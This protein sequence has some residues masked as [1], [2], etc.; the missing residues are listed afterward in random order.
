VQQVR[1]VGARV[2]VGAGCAWGAVLSCLALRPVVC[3]LVAVAAAA[4]GC[5]ALALIRGRALGGQLALCAFC[6]AV[7]LVPLAARQQR[8]ESSP[9][10]T[11]ARRHTTVTLDLVTTGDPQT[12][13]AHGV[14]G[15]PRVQVSARA[16][17]SVAGSRR[18]P[19]SGSVLIIAPAAQWRDLL[20]GQPIRATVQLAPSL[21][22]GPAGVTAFARDGPTRTGAPPWWQRAAGRVRSALRTAAAGLPEQPRGLLP[23]LVDGDTS[24]LDPILAEHFR[25]AGLTHL[26][27]V[28]G[29]NCSVLIGA[30]LL[31]M[32]RSRARPWLR[33]AVAFVVLVGFVLV[34]RPSPSVL[35]AAV[36]ATVALGALAAGRPRRGLPALAA[37]VV[38]L[39]AW[40]PLLARDVGFALSVFA[41]AAVLTIAP[42]LC[43]ALER[44]GLPRSIAGL[45]A[46]AAAAH[47]VTAPVIAAISGRVSLVTIP[48]NVVAEPVVAITTVLGFVVA[49]VAPVWAPA[50]AA[51]AQL[52]GL[53][54]R[55][56]V[57]DADF[58]GGLHGATLPWPAGLAGGLALAAVGA[59]IVALLVHSTTARRLVAA[60]VLVGVLVQIPVRS[61]VLHWPPNGWLFVACDVG[62]GDGLVLDAG[63]GSAVVVDSGPDP[64]PMDRCLSD[65]GVTAV[66]L[67]VFTHLHLDH[68]GGVAGVL[69][70]RQV[71][72]VVTGPLLEPVSG[73]HLV[74]AALRPRHL[75][76]GGLADGTSVRV[77]AV[78]LSV[79]GPAAAFHDTRSDPNN[80]SLVLRADVDGVRILLTGDAEIEAQQALL[81]ERVDL[82]AD[83]LKVPHHGSAYSL[84]AFLAAV[85]AQVGVISVGLHNDYG[86]PSPLLLHALERIGLPVRRTDH[87]GDVAFAGRPGAI[88][89]TTRGT[90]PS[91]VGLGPAAPPGTPS[92]LLRTEWAA[93][94]AHS[95]PIGPLAGDDRMGPCPPAPSRSTSCPTSSRRSSCWSATRSCSSPGR[96]ARSPPPRD[97]PTRTLS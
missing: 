53:P 43:D 62:Q 19:L 29:T 27:A 78:E 15:S 23:G 74:Q 73:L 14:A 40:D 11:L 52:A 24:G 2:A 16:R 61:V 60:A 50:G 32:R 31:A 9:L 68:V 86:H 65:L 33:A 20:P 91:T 64:V 17:A 66:P 49:L 56:L 82:T 38:L 79:L 10:A 80:S 55:W 39:L 46:V 97:G 96:S 37:A 5:A 8:A 1:L 21:A 94:A 63:P 44:R 30:V 4:C 58:F 92:G 87:D 77:G 26:V 41:T 47:L 28:S 54:C 81:D 85:H 76:L 83:V 89:T 67:L 57:L 18:T 45:F 51:V 48:A 36:M 25:V 71:H 69:H 6:V 70:G 3:L 12:L 22:P 59:G 88:V 84:P 34:A 95:S 13:A 90:R 42:V 7:V 93:V 75:D 72:R 35:R